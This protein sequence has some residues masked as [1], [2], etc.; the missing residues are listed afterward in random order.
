MAK[1]LIENG[2]DVHA[3]ANDGMT[4]LHRAAW[5]SMFA[6]RII[7]FLYT[8][9]DSILFTDRL[10]VGEVLLDNGADVNSKDNRDRKPKDVAKQYGNIFDNSNQTNQ[11]NSNETN[12]FF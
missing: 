5:Q 12:S 4:P 3:K 7:C 9:I 8:S 11:E 10:A 6:L 2:A 1:I